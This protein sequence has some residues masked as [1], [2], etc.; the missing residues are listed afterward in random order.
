MR[1]L[2]SVCSEKAASADIFYILS[3]TYVSHYVNSSLCNE[4]NIM[5]RL[6][7]Q[8]PRH[9][10]LRNRTAFYYIEK[11]IQNARL[12]DRTRRDTQRMTA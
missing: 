7:H 4:H 10:L 1:F 3:L 2:I 8:S 5:P 6:P 12:C 11:S 9:I